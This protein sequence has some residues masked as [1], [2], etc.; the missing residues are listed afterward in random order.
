MNEPGMFT[1]RRGFRLQDRM[2]I[3]DESG[4]VKMLDTHIV[5]AGSD[6]GSPVQTC[7]HVRHAKLRDMPESLTP[8]N[9]LPFPPRLYV[10]KHRHDLI[11][12]L[13]RPLK[14]SR[15]DDRYR[16]HWSC[17]TLRNLRSDHMR[18]IRARPLPRNDAI[19]ASL[20]FRAPRGITYRCM[21]HSGSAD[22][23][24]I[25]PARILTCAAEGAEVRR[26]LDLLI[27][28]N[29]PCI[30]RADIET[31]MAAKRVAFH[32][33][34]LDQPDFPLIRLENVDS[35]VRTD[36][37]APATCNTVVADRECT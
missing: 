13:L 24:R 29:M 7:C 21:R 28:R 11:E 33:M 3:T 16:R 6:H 20:P 2:I 15:I 27:R 12:P 36:A 14:Q 18:A 26:D 34:V 1:M 8:L 4:Y 9:P 32:E 10:S 5:I 25:E 35:V 23:D 30:R 22:R 31:R 17:L 19:D 37:S